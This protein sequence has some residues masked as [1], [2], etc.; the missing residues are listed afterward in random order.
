M[1]RPLSCLVGVETACLG[2]RGKKMER[3]KWGTREGGRRDRI[4]RAEHGKA[5]SVQPRFLVSAKGI[6]ERGGKQGWR[7]GGEF[8]CARVFKR[9]LVARVCEKKKEKEKKKT[10]E[11]PLANRSLLRLFLLIGNYSISSVWKLIDALYET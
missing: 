5:I 2:D 1:H 11:L 10:D 7:N 6:F 8:T 3:K 9:V 4:R